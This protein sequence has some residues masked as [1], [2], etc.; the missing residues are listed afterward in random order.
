MELSTNIQ[1]E[2]KQTHKW[3]D[4]ENILYRVSD[5]FQKGIDC[6]NW[7]FLTFNKQT[8]KTLSQS[9]I[10]ITEE[11]ENSIID[12]ILTINAL[13]PLPIKFDQI[14]DQNAN[15]VNLHKLGYKAHVFKTTPNFAKII[16]IITK[17]EQKTE[18]L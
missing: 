13:L 6:R 17:E 3:G 18:N 11:N 10:T 4:E 7:K 1:Q 15:S 14:K 2:K 12:F 5:T 9:G 16:F 8:A